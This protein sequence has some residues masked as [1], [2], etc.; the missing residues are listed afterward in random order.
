M[1]SETKNYQSALVLKRKHELLSEEVTDEQIS[2][3]LINLAKKMCKSHQFVSSILF[4]LRIGDR[5]DGFFRKRLH[6]AIRFSW[7]QV[8]V[9]YVATL[10]HLSK[11]R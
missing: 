9:S 5:R 2:Q 7:K 10:I 3:R 11:I 6:Y 1:A 4:M 8:S